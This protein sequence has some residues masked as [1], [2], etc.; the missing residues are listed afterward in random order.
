VVDLGFYTVQEGWLKLYHGSR[1]DEVV[2]FYNQNGFGYAKLWS[3]DKIPFMIPGDS[4]PNVAV[5]YE[6][7]GIYLYSAGW[8]TYMIHNN[9][10]FDD[11]VPIPGSL[12]LAG[13]GLL[14]LL[15]WRRSKRS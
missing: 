2:Q 8:T 11:P 3:D 6:T 9:D 12:L 7:T 10:D 1:L 15:A 13:T 14:G 4:D 5:G